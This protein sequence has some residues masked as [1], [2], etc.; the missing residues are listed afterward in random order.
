MSGSLFKYVQFVNRDQ[1]IEWGSTIQKVVCKQ[2]NIPGGDQ[3]EYWNECGTEVVLEVLK[4][5]RQ[6]VAMSMKTWFGREYLCFKCVQIM[7][8]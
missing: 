7:N 1:D 3:Q 8:V 4:R 6:A 5:K 2:C